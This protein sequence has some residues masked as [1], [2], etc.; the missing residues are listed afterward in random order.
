[1]GIF[2]SKPQPA[3]EKA[4]PPGRGSAAALSLSIVGA[5]MVVRG[6]LET[7]SVVKIEGTVD[8]HVR[9]S[10]QVLVAKG[11]VVHGDIETA[12]VIV[13]GVVNGA[14]RA[15]GRVEVQAGASIE[16]D[17]TTL[18]ISVAEGGT[19]NGHVKMGDGSLLQENRRPDAATESST[20]AASRATGP[21]RSQ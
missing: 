19:L 14:I 15:R 16:G 20:A 1:M 13:G 17:I 21:G 18:R 10:T 7:D 5:G 4:A 6:D 11:G 8:G 2:G 9:A 3:R 12:E